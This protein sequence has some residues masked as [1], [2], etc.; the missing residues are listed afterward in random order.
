[1]KR[2]KMKAIAIVD[3]TVLQIVQKPVVVAVKEPLKNMVLS[4]TAKLVVKVANL[5]GK[6]KRMKTKVI[7]IVDKTVLQIVQKPVVV[8]VK[9]P[10]KNMV[11]SSTAKLVVKV[12]A[13]A[14]KKTKTIRNLSLIL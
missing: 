12:A 4:S 3:K 6:M 13:L 14:G 10:L 11:L 5:A 2:M 9:E 7:A 8:A 1:M